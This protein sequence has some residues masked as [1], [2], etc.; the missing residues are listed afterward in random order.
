[1]LLTLNVTNGV[2][3]PSTLPSALPLRSQAYLADTM[4]MNFPRSD[5]CFLLSESGMCKALLAQ[6]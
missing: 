5:Q 3:S 4:K 1:V 2:P 6:G